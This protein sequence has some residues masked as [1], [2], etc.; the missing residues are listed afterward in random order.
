MRGAGGGKHNEEY[1]NLCELEQ[2][3]LGTALRKFGGAPA[4]L[5]E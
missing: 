1:A 5:N 2:L 3:R 4:E